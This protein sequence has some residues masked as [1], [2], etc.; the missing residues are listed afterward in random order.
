VGLRGTR[1]VDGARRSALLVADAVASAEVPAA[2][3]PGLL[4]AREGAVLAAAVAWLAVRPDVLL[5]DAT[6]RD[7]PRGAGLAVH[8]GWA[9]GL[10]TVGVTSRAL[11]AAG[12]PPGPERGDWSPLVLAG[13]EVGRWLRTR[14]RARPVLVHAAWRTDPQTA[15]DVVLRASTLAARTPVPLQEARRVAREA[16]SDAGLE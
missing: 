15:A 11:V 14:P 5:V 6:G 12:I 9:C 7:H 1:P 2:Y 4:A 8:L 13:R 3:Q 10:P 16:R